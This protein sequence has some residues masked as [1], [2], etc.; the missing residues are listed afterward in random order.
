MQYFLENDTFCWD[1]LGDLLSQRVNFGYVSESAFHSPKLAA[2]F[3]GEFAI[4]EIDRSRT[5]VEFG[6]FLVGPQFEALL[7]SVY[8][9]AQTH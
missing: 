1:Q 2:V 3:S 8:D 4:F 6:E 5:R 7:V 9:G